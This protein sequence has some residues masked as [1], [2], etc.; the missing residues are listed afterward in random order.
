V[1]DAALDSLARGD[2][3][4]LRLPEPSPADVWEQLAAD[5]AASRT[6]LRAVEASYWKRWRCAYRLW[7]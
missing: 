2:A 1:S 6:H 3:D 4:G 7:L 5:L